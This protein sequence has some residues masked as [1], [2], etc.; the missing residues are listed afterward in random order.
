MQSPAAAMP[1]HVSIQTAAAVLDVNPKTVRRMIAA[2]ALPAVRVGTRR[3]GTLRD[4]R[5]IR[6]PADALASLV[7]PVTTG[8]VR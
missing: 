1:Q 6:I 4:T 2:G 7:E 3:P 5:R 8:G